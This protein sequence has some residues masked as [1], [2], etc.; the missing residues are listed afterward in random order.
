MLLWIIVSH[1]DFDT[2]LMQAFLLWPLA[3]RRYRSVRFMGT[4]L[5]FC[6][7]TGPALPIPA[8]NC[9]FATINPEVGGLRS[10]A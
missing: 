4:G 6:Y 1:G 2:R 3:W 10:I 5:H 7:G 9:S 8:A